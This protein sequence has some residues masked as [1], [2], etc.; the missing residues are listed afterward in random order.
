MNGMPLVC[1]DDSGLGM[2][3]FTMVSVWLDLVMV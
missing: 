3:V 2:R 1:T